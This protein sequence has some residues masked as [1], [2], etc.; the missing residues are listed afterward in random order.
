MSENQNQTPEQ[1]VENESQSQET[2]ST[3]TVDIDKLVNEKVSETLK[4]IKAKLD[5]SYQ[6]RDEAL[7]KVAEFENEKKAAELKRLQE[8]GK[9]KEAYEMQL[10][11]EKAKREALEKQNVELTRDISV[12]QALAQLPFRNEKAVEMAYKEIVSQLVRDENGLWVHKS[13]LQI[14]DFVKA[15]SDSD[16]NTFLFKTKV[17]SGNGGDSVKA[18]SSVADATSLFALSQDEVLKRAREGKLRR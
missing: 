18:P 5:K 1:N 15:F 12:R 13:G 3:Q 8:E 2:S 4:E 6:A 10:A 16:E 7:K 11:E 9:F 14:Q 17:N